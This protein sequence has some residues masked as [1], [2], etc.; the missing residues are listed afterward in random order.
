MYI[1]YYRQWGEQSDNSGVGRHYYKI[2]RQKNDDSTGDD[3]N[4]D[5]DQDNYYIIADYCIAT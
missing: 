2:K 1:L 3:I 4:V 5:Q